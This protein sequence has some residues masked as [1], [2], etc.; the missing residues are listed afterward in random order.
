M[1]NIYILLI[2]FL[3]LSC[4][5]FVDET[6][7][8]KVIP[9]TVDDFGMILDGFDQFDSNSMTYGINN[10]TLMTDDIT[11]TDA[12]GN[13]T[14]VIG[15]N[16]FLWEDYMYNFDEDDDDWNH[17]YH[18]IY[19]SNFVI[20]SIDEAPEGAGNYNRDVVKGTALLYRAYN[21]FG[22]VNLYAK[23]YD[24][25]TASTDLGVPLKIASD[26]NE[27]IGRATVAQVYEQIEKDLDDAQNLLPREVEYSFRGTEQAVYGLKA[28]LHLYKGEYKL[29]WKA[30]EQAR[31]LSREIKDYNTIIPVMEGQPDFGFTNWPTAYRAWERPDVIFF[32][33][34]SDKSEAYYMSD[35]LLGLFDQVNDLRF[36]L[37]CT[38]LAFYSFSPDPN[39]TRFSGDGDCSR[40]ITLGEIYLNEAEAKLRDILQNSATEVTV[41]DVLDV[42]NQLRAKRYKTGVVDITETDP[43][44]LL[45]IVLKER[46]RECMFKGLRWFDLKRLNKETAFKKTISHTLYGET[47]TLEPE[48]NKYILPI[49]RKVIALNPLIEQ[50]P[51]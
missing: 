30:A 19:L 25:N 47:K 33:D 35:E 45:D 42:L 39:G 43:L 34:A 41:N 12:I 32:K 26:V 16:A 11:M 21:Y 29:A 8:G 9:K 6:P 15:L 20:E 1:K 36:S 49:P 38:D 22:L 7:K 27:K 18:V 40:G 50:N 17:L 44:V 23:H 37:F 31:L 13:Q 4:Q 2:S 28:R 14:D 51:R 3:L 48:D 10:M 5:D 24:K 46:R